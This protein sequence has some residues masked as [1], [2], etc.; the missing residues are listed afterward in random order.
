MGNLALPAYTLPA[1]STSFGKLT[2]GSFCC[3]GLTSIIL[4][5]ALSLR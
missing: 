2:Y 3:V 1:E 5:R 4:N